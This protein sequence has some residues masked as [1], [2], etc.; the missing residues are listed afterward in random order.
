M[1]QDGD[2]TVVAGHPR[3]QGNSDGVGLSARFK[4]CQSIFSDGMGCLYCFDS[5]R[6]RRLQL[7]P[8]WHS[9]TVAAAPNVGGGSGGR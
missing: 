6:L 8:A 4:S 3:E 5:R 2:A 9:A 1:S 7:P